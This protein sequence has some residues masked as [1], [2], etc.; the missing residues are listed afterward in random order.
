MILILGKNGYIS[1]RFQDF[2]TLRGIPFQAV[3]LRNDPL[4]IYTI[5]S[6]VWPTMV[7]NCI[8]FTGIPNIEACENQKE[9][10][11]S[12]NVNLA[13]VI[14]E[15]CKKFHIPLG[16]VSS[17]CIFKDRGDGV[18]FSETSLPNF[19][20]LLG[21]ASWYSGTKALGESIVAKTWEQTWVWRI[22][23]PFNHLDQPKNI[24]T[25]YL[26]YPRI[27]NQKNSYTNLD[28]FVEMAASFQNKKI[29]YGIY[30]MTNPGGIDPAQILDI[31]R[32]EGFESNVQELI[33]D[34][35]K[36]DSISSIPR[37]DCILDTTKSS[38]YGIAML[39]VG[40][41]FRKCFQNWNRD[42]SPFWNNMG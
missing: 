8:G 29:P 39:D 24:I 36:F 9:E 11:L 31:A 17:G 28:E 38:K 4:Q 5:L 6:E 27:W 40:A 18:P 42:I 21:K 33:S 3:S 22:R 34:P 35:A 13:E 23:M 41:S 7:I 10:C 14:A 30:N 32:R 1:K 26:K 12:V 37:S 19:T 16:F 2:F 15:A 20:F 25:K